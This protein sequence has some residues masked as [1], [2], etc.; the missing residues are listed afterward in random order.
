MHAHG[1]HLRSF[2][3]CP[4]PP[5]QGLS[6]ER[7]RAYPPGKALESPSFAVD[8]THF[9][10]RLYPGG[11]GCEAS[12]GHASASLALRTPGRRCAVDYE[13]CALNQATGLPLARDAGARELGVDAEGAPLP[14]AAVA[15]SAPRF[16]SHARAASFRAEL[17]R[18][19]VL[20]LT[21]RVTL[22]AAA[23]AH[24]DARR[25]VVVPP[26]CIAGDW[27]AML[28][29]GEGADVRFLIP[30]ASAASADAPP[31]AFRAHRVVLLGRA[32]GMRSLLAAPGAAA[33]GVRV[34]GLT[35]PAFGALLHYL[36]TEELESEPSEALAAELLAA[37]DRFDVPR[38]GALAGARLAA[39]LR[40]DSAAATLALADAH[41]A[42]GLKRAAA[43][44]VGANAS[45]V[46]ATDGWEALCAARPALLAELMR[47][48]MQQ[49]QMA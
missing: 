22:A 45:A 41:R 12:R 38:L 19:N 36:Y 4:A 5:A 10:L 39:A 23:D 8:D 29:S 34:E 46:M 25:H 9:V 13:L 31:A 26:K 49:Q 27:A 28:A 7:L 24:A 44:F 42:P 17:L 37:A 2:S 47:A 33:G 30:D 15:T 21:A 20:I 6:L 3:R 40:V 14:W 48:L 32:R 18:A 35:P 1:S 11:A 43:E 16:L